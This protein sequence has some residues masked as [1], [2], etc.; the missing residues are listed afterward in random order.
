MLPRAHV[1]RQPAGVPRLT[2]DQERVEDQAAHAQVAD[3]VTAAQP[4]LHLG[5]QPGITV[6]LRRHVPVGGQPIQGVAVL[7]GLRLGPRVAGPVGQP[8]PGPAAAV[9]RRP[10]DL[11]GRVIVPVRGVGV[12]VGEP[13]R[14]VPPAV[15]VGQREE[16]EEQHALALVEPVVADLE[17]VAEHAE[18]GELAHYPVPMPAAGLQQVVGPAEQV[19]LGPVEEHLQEVVGAVPGRE[20]P[21]VAQRPVRPGVQPGEPP[22]ALIQQPEQGPF[23]QRPV[24]RLQ[25]R[26][27]GP[28]HRPHTGMRGRGSRTEFCVCRP[29]HLNRPLARPCGCEGI[30]RGFAALGEQQI[31][32][33]K[34]RGL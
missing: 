17:L 28:D 34:A 21:V 15:R 31:R 1:A 2:A 27:R 3:H 8:R 26:H 14:P 12:Q 5:A 25:A 4:A 32:R 11:P 20:L 18:P 24:R 6:I 29:D 13:H 22:P 7:G 9:V 19:Q 33:E 10:D 23:G 16:V 30:E